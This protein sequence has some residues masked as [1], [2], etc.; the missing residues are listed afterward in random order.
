MKQWCHSGRQ[1]GLNSWATYIQIQLLLLSSQ[2]PVCV[3][4]LPKAGTETKACIKELIWE[5]IPGS[6]SKRIKE[7]RVQLL[8]GVGHWWDSQCSVLQRL[9]EAPYKR[10]FLVTHL[11]SK[12]RSTSGNANFSH[13]WCVQVRALVDYGP[14][15]T[16]WG[17]RSPI[18]S[19]R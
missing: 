2:V 17:W 14:Q 15:S 8:Y 13:L 3:W 6:R 7:R 16:P 18:G 12:L 19:K 4:I 5:M 9:S 10:C 1:H 11:C